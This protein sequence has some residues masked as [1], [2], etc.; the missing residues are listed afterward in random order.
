[1]SA[2][3]RSQA[4]S[5]TA[6]PCKIE[7]PRV[8]EFVVS[9]SAVSIRY[10]RALIDAARD[11][12]AL[13]LVEADVQALLDLLRASEDLREFVADP[14]IQSDRKRAVL[15]ELLAGKIQGI[16]LRFL[17]LLCDKGRERMLPELLADFLS[18]LEDRRGR[19]TAQLAVA[20]P[21]SSEQEARLIAKLSTHSGKQVKL[22]TTVDRRLKAGFVVRLGDRVFDGTLATQLD[23]L[24]QRLASE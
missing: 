22:E 23:R 20:A 14:M 9:P 16:T 18:A 6:C 13:D 5:S 21:L 17:L 7:R 8:R 24:R 3:A 2:T 1:M 4:I 12:D 19:A 11:S 10:T 15:N